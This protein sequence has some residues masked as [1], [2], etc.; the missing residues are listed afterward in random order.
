[1]PTTRSACWLGAVAWLAALLGG[2]SSPAPPPARVRET[3]PRDT[4]STTLG[5][6]LADDFATH[7]GAS[8]FYPLPFGL[9]ALLARLAL[10]RAAERSVDV[11][12][13]MLHDD[14]T[15]RALLG[16]LIRAADRGVNV[17]LLLDDIHTQGHDEALATLAA[18]P[19][20]A[21]RLFNPFHHRSAR[22]ID[23]LF[24]FSRVNRR[25]HNKSLT[26]DNQ[27]TIVGG[28]NIGDEYFA[29]SSDVDFSDLDVMAAGPVVPLVS[30]VFDEYWNSA[31]TIPIAEVTGKPPPDQA[32][33]DRLHAQFT[34]SL[35][36][37]RGTAYA[38]TLSDLAHTLREKRLEV[39]WG[40]G[41][42]IADRPN[43]VVLPTD[44]DSTHAVP[45]LRQT[46]GA[47]QSELLLV[48]PYF[49]PGRN[50]QRW[51]EA[52]AKRGVRIRVLT[53]SYRAT[54]V[55]AVHSGYMPYRKPLLRAGIELYELKP[56][57]STTAGSNR[58]G[59]G[60]SSSASLHAKTY[61]ADAHTLFVG[62]FNLD[63]RSAR[64]NTEMGLVLD[65]APL[66]ARV[67][68]NFDTRILDF[69]YRVEL[70][71][72]DGDLTW[73]TREQGRETR[74]KSEPGVGP[75][76]RFGLFLKRLLPIE[77]QL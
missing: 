8:A 67:A 73:V 72:K 52:V 15:G 24:S 2:C 34:R 57:A 14:Q 28:R 3:A 70:D 21:V 31:V 74:F 65:S 77:E 71:P 17:R 25:M 23:L 63:P 44:D 29:A 37:A 43:K 13:Y 42:V 39:F 49:V 58:K 12:Y 18:H 22:W 62:S 54:D 61:I 55:S 68:G 32:T 33:K 75:F 9:E 45:Q 48:S 1:M 4:A 56:K 38:N 10:V 64:L 26:V 40:S 36:Q 41:S 7:P 30:D 16:E 47:A 35:E 51:L 50:G 66:A 46:L 53:N 69:A 27:L 6:I 11:Q 59:F 76:R 5:R 60:G 20:I 19:R